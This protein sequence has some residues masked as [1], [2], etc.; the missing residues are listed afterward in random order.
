[1]LKTQWAENFQHTRPKH[2]QLCRYA[3][4]T[5]IVTRL[6]CK[7]QTHAGMGVGG[8][9][10][11]SKAVTYKYPKM[12]IC[13][14]G[15]VPCNWTECFPYRIGLDL[16]KDW[17]T[18]DAGSRWLRAPLVQSLQAAKLLLFC[19]ESGQ[20]TSWKDK[21]WPEET[22][23]GEVLRDQFMLCTLAEFTIWTI[24]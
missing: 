21:E 10:I 16:T 11:N 7:L 18:A 9:G 23:V 5:H 17:K 3:R 20:W 2:T 22:V 4:D 19:L 8:G 14:N 12:K 24:Y 6:H 13:E 1:M 15:I